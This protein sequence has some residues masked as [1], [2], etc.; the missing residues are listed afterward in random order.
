MKLP[1]M[2]DLALTNHPLTYRSWAE[3]RAAGFNWKA[4]QSTL[5]PTVDLQ[6]TYRYTDE[7]FGGGGAGGGI[8][9]D[10]SAD[11]DAQ[12]VVATGGSGGGQGYFK[13]LTTAVSVNYL[14]LDFGGRC[15]SIKAA[16]EALYAANWRH[17]RTL[18]G[19]IFNLLQTYYNY[20]GSIALLKAFKADVEDARKNLKAA[21]GLFEAGVSTRV[22][23]LQARSNFVNAELQVALEKGR[24]DIL[25]GELAIAMGLPANA[26]FEVED[27]PD[28]LPIEKVQESL[29]ELVEAAQEQR[30][31][32]AAAYAVY[33][34]RRAESDVIFSEGMPTIN[35][36]MDYQKVNFTNRPSLN[37]RVFSVKVGLDIPL[38]AGFLYVQRERE[39]AAL[40]E[41]AYAE[42]KDLETLA[43]QDVVAG[44]SEHVTAIE[45]I[46]Y[47]EEYLKFAQEASNAALLSYKLGTDTILS[48]LTA[49]TVLSNARR[50]R[51]QARTQW[52][53]SLANLSYATGA[54]QGD[55]CE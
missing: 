10:A 40:A 14:L 27:L 20:M 41:A 46:K 53:V 24:L 21:E 26:E 3:A 12:D 42:M 25:H 34:Q 19:V 33:L 52:L 6:E 48:A 16:L 7:K 9:G 44:Y 13:T 8:G 23:V 35:A 43:T 31:D 49:Q 28:E 1:E 37:G 45:S 30:P 47:S 17:N 29:D 2:L 5:Y 22:D 4:S 11:A 50:Q 15:S 55:F 39:A 38:F 54:L 36:E 18:Q 51:V 32:L